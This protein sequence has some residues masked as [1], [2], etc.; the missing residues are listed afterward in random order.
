MSLK[1]GPGTATNAI[2]ES[3]KQD[4]GLLLLNG[5]H[6]QIPQQHQNRYLSHGRDIQGRLPKARTHLTRKDEISHDRSAPYLARLPQSS[7][8]PRHS[9]THTR[10]SERP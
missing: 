6:L 1:A 4:Q 9:R 10:P 7:Y 3:D 2:F 8:Q 5:T